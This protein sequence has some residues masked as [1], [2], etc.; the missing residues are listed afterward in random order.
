MKL[1]KNILSFV[2]LA[3]LFIFVCIFGLLK[4]NLKLNKID[5]KYE[6]NLTTYWKNKINKVNIHKQY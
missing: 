1:T 5:K 2:I 4:K 3:A 6:R